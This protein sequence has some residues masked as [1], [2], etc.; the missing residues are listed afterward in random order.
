MDHGDWDRWNLDCFINY[1]EVMNTYVDGKDRNMDL[2]MI[3]TYTGKPDVVE[4]DLYTN[5]YIYEMII[6]YLK[7]DPPA[8]W[9]YF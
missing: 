2:E 8:R 4:N 5:R 1:G 9:M 7:S 3:L 6:P